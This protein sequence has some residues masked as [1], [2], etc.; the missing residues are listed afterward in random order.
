MASPVQELCVGRFGNLS[1]YFI[2]ITIGDL[3]HMTRDDVLGSVTEPQHRMLMAAFYGEVLSP[4][5]S[6]PKASTLAPD[7]SAFRVLGRNPRTNKLDLSVSSSGG[8]NLRKCLVS[9]A[10]QALRPSVATVDNVVASLSPAESLSIRS[11]DMSNNDIMDTDL[12]TLKLF[13]E[14]LRNIESVSLANNH[15]HG[16]H[17]PFGGQ[18]DEL[19][20]SLLTR[21][22]IKFVDITGNNCASIDKIVFFRS[23]AAEHISRLIFVPE[24]LVSTS[25][26]HALLASADLVPKVYAAH[27]RYFQGIWCNGSLSFS[28]Q[29]L[30]RVNRFREGDGVR[31]S[32]PPPPLKE[33]CPPWRPRRGSLSS[34][35]RVRLH[36]V[37]QFK[38][39][40]PPLTH[41]GNGTSVSTSRWLSFLLA[42]VSSTPVISCGRT[43]T[44]RF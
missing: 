10:V 26:W 2:G 17:E 1:A 44:T 3:A 35:L 18:L 24:S 30:A 39:K 28:A 9:V 13:F 15:L 20:R 29:I 37:H 43:S 31:E 21:D 40:S 14:P 36:K 25:G 41:S 12:V 38:P 6:T 5:R 22:A 27:K 8:L 34:S 33:L 7:S 4:L 32:T 11:V 23:L 16:L 19:L 42:A